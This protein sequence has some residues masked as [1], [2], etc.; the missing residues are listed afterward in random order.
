MREV[1]DL[2][3]AAKLELAGSERRLVLA[4]TA[5]ADFFLA[6]PYGDSGKQDWNP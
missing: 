1:I 5:L 3:S 2:L 4:K 6:H